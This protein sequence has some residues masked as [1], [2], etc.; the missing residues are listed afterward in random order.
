LREGPEKVEGAEKLAGVKDAGKVEENVI[1][2][3]P[4]DADATAAIEQQV[5]KP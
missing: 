4:Q 3:L 5:G 2:E 1:V